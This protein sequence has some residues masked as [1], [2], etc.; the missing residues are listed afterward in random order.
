MRFDWRENCGSMQMAIKPSGRKREPAR[1]NRQRGAILLLFALLLVITGSWLGLRMLGSSRAI[2]VVRAPD[3]AL[4]EARDAIIGASMAMTVA[5]VVRPGQLPTPDFLDPAEAPANYDGNFNACALST[6]VAGAALPVM[7]ATPNAGTRCFG[8]L[9]WATLGLGMFGSSAQSDPAGNV[10]WYAMSVNLAPSTCVR[11]LNPGLLNTTYAPGTCGSATVTQ[12]FP[13]LTVRDYKG[14]L[15][16]DRAAFVLLLPGP[17]LG[18]QARPGTTLS[19]PAAYLDTVTVT[20]ACTRP[21]V[22]GTYDNARFNWPNNVGLSF[23][24]CAPPSQVSANDPSFTQPYQC[25]DRIVYVTIDELMEVAERRATQHIADA[26]RTY[27]ASNRF[28]PF[29]A[30]LSQLTLTPRLRGQCE[31]GTTIGLAPTV[32]T[33]L[34]SVPPNPNPC[35]HPE[36]SSLVQGWFNANSWGDY[37]IYNVAPDCTQPTPAASGSANCGGATGVR[38]AAGAVADA[39]AIVIG[40]GAPIVAAP[41]AASRG[42]AQSRTGAN[43]AI[44]ANYLDSV[45]NT[46]NTAT[47]NRFDAPTTALTRSYNDKTL[48]VAP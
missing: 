10:P 12:P 46:N 17:P 27:Y 23:I 34:V 43:L 47:D 24:Q 16:T 20:A 15:L 36:F 42:A 29:A 26:L 30:P 45:E 37:L 13:W 40:A 44:L 38:L 2:S 3:Q 14:N 11:A 41:F 6:W 35:T 5:N 1:L 25:N 7:G 9:P 31:N 21:C 19:G 18:G 4:K 28:F 22:P 48:V 39:R 33:T 8:R 32:A